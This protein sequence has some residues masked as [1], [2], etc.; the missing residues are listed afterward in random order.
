MTSEMGRLPEAGD[1]V[2][3]EGYR[4]TILEVDGRRILKMRFEREN[5]GGDRAGQAGGEED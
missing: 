3:L 4:V 2:G 5:P 1:T